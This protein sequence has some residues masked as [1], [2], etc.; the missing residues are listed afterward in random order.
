[1]GPRFRAAAREAVFGGSCGGKRLTSGPA[2]KS[3]SAITEVVGCSWRGNR[4]TGSCCFTTCGR[5]R[6]ISTFGAEGSPMARRTYPLGFE[7]LEGQKD[8]QS[9]SLDEGDCRELVP[10]VVTQGRERVG[11]A[12]DKEGTITSGKQFTEYIRLLGCRI[13]SSAWRISSDN[14]DNFPGFVRPA[15]FRR[16]VAYCLPPASSRREATICRKAVH[17]PPSA[18]F[19]REAALRSLPASSRREAAIA[20]ETA[21]RTPSAF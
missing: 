18:F 1:M 12:L 8:V 2:G 16:E 7:S 6:N 11:G 4:S 13:F 17:F 5:N 9:I 3:E 21:H 19:R 15:S 10:V 14:C 20:R